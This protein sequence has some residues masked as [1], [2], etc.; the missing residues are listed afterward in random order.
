MTIRKWETRTM[1]RIFF[2]Y[3]GVRSRKGYF[4]TTFKT[5]LI[6][7]CLFWARTLN[8]EFIPQKNIFMYNL[9]VL[10]MNL[11][12]A[13][14]Y[15][16]YL[17]CIELI[18]LGRKTMTMKVEMSTHRICVCLFWPWVEKSVKKMEQVVGAPPT[19][20]RPL[21]C[22]ISGT[23]PPARTT[24]TDDYPLSITHTHKLTHMRTH[25]HK[26]VSGDMADVFPASNPYFTPLSWYKIRIEA[27]SFHRICL[28]CLGVGADGVIDFRW[29]VG[30]SHS[31]SWEHW[32]DTICDRVN[33][34]R[35]QRKIHDTWLQWWWIHNTTIDRPHYFGTDD[36]ST[37]KPAF[38]TTTLVINSNKTRKIN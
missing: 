34:G 26:C 3:F 5:V 14:N 11:F 33:S 17:T 21:S 30:A 22:G 25:A 18:G 20:A 36:L 24:E 35:N 8:I 32:T 2:V 23:T 1:I 16:G 15:V 27:G 7:H 6:K 13:H 12:Y 9:P 10:S 19:E 4:E 29:L 28:R 37:L 31:K 38:I